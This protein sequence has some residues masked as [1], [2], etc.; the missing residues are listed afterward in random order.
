MKFEVYFAIILTLLMFSC[1]PKP[2]YS[3]STPP[4][5]EDM[6][7]LQSPKLKL[8]DLKGKVVLMRWWTDECMFCINSAEA[9]NEWYQMYADSGLVIIGL[10]HPKPEPKICDPEEVREFV[11]DKEFRFPIAIDEHW[12]NLK[13]FWL[14]SGSK[15]FTSVSFLIDRMGI[16]KYIHSGGEYH[17]LIAEGH[18][19]CVDDY[20]VLK[21]KIEESIRSK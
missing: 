12:K 16:I 3:D 11:L 18:E 2:S 14:N 17:K 1:K 9:L 4:E 15:D 10:Y 19:K 5:F 7:W 6:E 20:F 8:A 13:I 21:R